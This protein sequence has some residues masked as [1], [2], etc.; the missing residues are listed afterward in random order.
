MSFYKQFA[1]PEVLL[2][3]VQGQDLPVYPVNAHL[4]TPFSFSAFTSIA[5]ALDRAVAEGVKVVG[6]NDFTVP[7]GTRVGCV[8][9]SPPPLP[10]FQYRIHQSESVLQ[11]AGIRANDPNNPGRVSGGKDFVSR[12]VWNSLLVSSKVKAASNQHVAQCARV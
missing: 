3:S 11:D 6:I 4:H 10:A 2:E 5:D 1:D 12:C 8:V 7:T 9:R